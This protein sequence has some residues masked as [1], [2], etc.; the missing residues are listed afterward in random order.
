[1][2]RE[3]TTSVISGSTDHIL[4]FLSHRSDR[5]SDKQKQKITTTLNVTLLSTS[6]S[7]IPQQKLSHKP[8]S[9]GAIL[10]T[11]WLSETNLENPKDSYNLRLKSVV[12]DRWFNMFID[13]R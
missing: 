9:H 8:G 2:E 1:M 10:A 6:T 4:Q 7:S 3:E 11:I 12:F 5:F 13:S